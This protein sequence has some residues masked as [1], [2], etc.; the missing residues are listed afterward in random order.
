KKRSTKKAIITANPDPWDIDTLIK[1]IPMNR[2][3][4]TDKVAKWQDRIDER[5]GIRDGKITFIDENYSEAFTKGLLYDVN[6]LVIHIE[7]M[8]I[9][10]SDKIRFHRAVEGMLTR[11]AS[12]PWDNLQPGYFIRLVENMEEMM[13]AIVENEMDEF[14]KE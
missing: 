5:D 3:L 6:L 1:P 7:N 13:I 10:H 4:F 12:M 11:V 9:D 14:V 8:N 2:A